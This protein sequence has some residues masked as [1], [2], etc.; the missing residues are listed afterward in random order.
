MTK[1]EKSLQDTVIE[2][3]CTIIV[4]N[5]YIGDHLED[6]N[7]LY[8]IADLRGAVA[9]SEESVERA[10]RTRLD[11]PQKGFFARLFNL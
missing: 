1:N 4:L 10:R 7:N 9:M 5:R 8:R 2:L 3:E 11:L 6:T